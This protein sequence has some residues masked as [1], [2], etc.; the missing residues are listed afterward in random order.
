MINIFNEL[1][2]GLKQALTSN[3]IEGIDSIGTSSVYT[4]KPSSYPFV[5][6]EE[7]NDSVYEQGGDCCEIENFANKEYEI[8]VYTQKPHKRSNANSIANVV[9][10][11]FK[12]VG[13]T[14][15]SKTPL[16]ENDETTYRIVLRYMGIVSK[17][18][19]VYR[20]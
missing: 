19:I 11:Y 16:Q 9:D 7:I 3:T 18:H 13:F 2:T 12:S 6:M 10:N 17:D 1:F 4:N 8:M 14:R 20:R 5:S 15:I